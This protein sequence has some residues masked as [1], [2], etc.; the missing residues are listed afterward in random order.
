MGS[1]G[2]N[3]GGNWND[4]LDM[5]RVDGDYVISF[6]PHQLTNGQFSISYASIEGDATVKNWADY[7]DPEKLALMTAEA[8]SWITCNWYDQVHDCILD[9][10]GND[11]CGLSVRVTTD[12]QTCEFKPAGNMTHYNSK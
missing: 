11:S 4:G 1:L 9:M 2:Q 8:L 5:T 7:G 10:T 12:G 6:A 3:S